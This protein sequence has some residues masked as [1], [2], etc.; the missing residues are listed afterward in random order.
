M[1][2]YIFL[3][4]I[5]LSFFS[6]G[7]NT[8]G[9]S[10]TPKECSLQ[11]FAQKGQ[12]TKGSQVTA[13]AVGPDLVATG[14]SFPSNISDDLGSFSISG[15]TTAPFLELR[16]EGYYFNELEGAISHSPLYLEAFVKADDIEANINL[17]TTA[18]RPRV[19]KLIR[20]GKSFQAAVSQAQN[21]FLNAFGFSGDADSFDHLDITGTSESDGMLLAF[22]CMVQNGRSAA[23]VTTLIQEIA[24]DLENTGDLTPSVFDKTFS[25][26]K[27]VNPFA[28]IE[29]MARYYSEKR[30]AVNTVPPFWKYL[31]SNY[32][33][34]FLL[35]DHESF[36]FLPEPVNVVSSP[37]K[38]AD[39]I[40]GELDALSSINFTVEADIPGATATKQQLFGPA[41]HITFRIPANESM[42]ERTAHI[43]FKDARGN[44][45][46]QRE[47]VQG[48]GLQYLILQEPET[49]K[50][51]T[52]GWISP[53]HED[54]ELSVNGISYRTQRFRDLGYALGVAV[55]PA[56]SYIVSYPAGKV[57]YG[58]HIIR[59][60][61]T[62]ESNQSLSQEMYYCGALAPY[63]GI[64]V[65]NPAKVFLEPCLAAVKIVPHQAVRHVEFGASMPLSGT[66]SFVVNPK[67]L[68]YF[69]DV[70]PNIL[71]D[72]GTGGN[73]SIDV[74]YG[75]ES[76]FC[77]TFPQ[78]IESGLRINYTINA[79]GIIIQNSYTAIDLT[80]L[81]AGN[82][83]T[84]YFGLDEVRYTI[85]K[86]VPE[87]DTTIAITKVQ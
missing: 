25:K 87:D 46:A 62:I 8:N 5:S 40:S 29:N 52:T 12:F 73:I 9:S 1:K 27:T 7:K 43:I 58:E 11:G 84:F 20:E 55:T 69:P 22:A 42:E 60:R 17:M 37:F 45:L 3:G 31:D 54:I 24:S 39:A 21:E 32:N 53:F 41:Y 66:A 44:I 16:A 83:Y 75:A 36:P 81:Q 82:L 63:D 80:E 71:F 10:S 57:L 35:V 30:L 86:Y 49:T 48:A 74:P 26:A 64:S 65:P 79:D 68:S 38:S 34:P 33:A 67:N 72:D 85:S 56:E 15:K 76:I 61:T 19:K 70:N 78:V 50:A 18:I 14:E 77:V 59:V 47:Y 28:V 6:C 51:T 23:E 4:L 13:F 2:K